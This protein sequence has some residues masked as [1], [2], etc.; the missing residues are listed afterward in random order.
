LIEAKGP[1]GATQTMIVGI[2][3]KKKKKK[4]KKK[5]KNPNLIDK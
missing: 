5:R 4:K 2:M 1:R 3:F